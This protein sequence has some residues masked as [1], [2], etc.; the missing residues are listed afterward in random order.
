MTN[1]HPTPE[2]PT[3]KVTTLGGM[4]TTLA[5][6]EDDRDCLEVFAELLDTKNEGLWPLMLNVIVEPVAGAQILMIGHVRPG[7]TLQLDKDLESQ[8][9]QL[10][11]PETG[12]DD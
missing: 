9:V 1:P 2:P 6:S 10:W 12:Y 4:L 8:V 7:M 5:R 3:A 11:F